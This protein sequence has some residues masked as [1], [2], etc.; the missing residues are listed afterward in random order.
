MLKAQSTLITPLSMITNTGSMQQRREFTTSSTL[1]TSERNK[2]KTVDP[3]TSDLG[4]SKSSLM[5]FPIEMGISTA[6]T[7]LTLVLQAEHGVT[8]LSGMNNRGMSFQQARS[9]TLSSLTT[10][11]LITV[12]GGVLSVLI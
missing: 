3:Q 1:T 4:R 6:I 8:Q 7:I 10:P 9:V 2:K 5:S 12:F 11:L